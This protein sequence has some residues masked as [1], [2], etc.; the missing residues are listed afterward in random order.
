MG[1]LGRVA[2]F[3]SFFVGRRQ[4]LSGEV[5]C[6]R[7][8]GHDDTFVD[9]EHRQRVQRRIMHQHQVERRAR[10]RITRRVGRRGRPRLAL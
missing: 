6:A 10:H 9:Q 4:I 5:G 2:A 1:L 3:R 7:A 8:S